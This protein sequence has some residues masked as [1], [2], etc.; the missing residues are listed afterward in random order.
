[1][2]QE[3]P[4]MLQKLPN[5]PAPDAERDEGKDY[6]GRISGGFF[7]GKRAR[8]EMLG[9]ISTSGFIPDMDL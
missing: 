4:N 6:R 9:Y 1:M 5:K 3:L 8:R 2:Q 7:L